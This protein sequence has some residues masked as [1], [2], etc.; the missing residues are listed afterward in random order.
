MR[1]RAAIIIF[2]LSFFQLFFSQENENFTKHQLSVDF[3]SFRNRYLYPITN[4]RYTSPIF[5]KF[6]LRISA[7][8]RSYGTLFFFSKSAYDLSPV[9]DYFFTDRSKTFNFSAGLGLD[10]RLRFIHDE[11]SD[12]ASSAEPFV[13]FAAYCSRKKFS[14]NMP[15]WTRFYSNGISFT[16]LP[17][18][19][20][21]VSK[22]CSLLFRY[23]LGLLSVYKLSTQEWRRDCFLGAVYSF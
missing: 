13:S 1:K 9:A 8:F 7:R 5:E 3:G 4:I 14:V 18:V 11:R 22:K 6:N 19:A 20:F 2:C 10:A 23:E 16:I 21:A 12:A 15:L 17:E